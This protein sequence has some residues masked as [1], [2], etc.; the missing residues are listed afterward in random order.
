MFVIA[1]MKCVSSCYMLFFLSTRRRHTRC[2]L[3]TGV[4]TCALPI[5]FQRRVP[6]ACEAAEQ[7][8]G[9]VVVVGDGGR[10]PG[11]VAL[12]REIGRASCRE[13]VCQY[14]S[15]PVVGVSLKKNIYH[16]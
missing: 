14:V 2:E 3:V 6:I 1:V 4:Q 5:S 16:H 13:R 15:L 8:P 7:G 9:R 10:Q 11:R 12:R